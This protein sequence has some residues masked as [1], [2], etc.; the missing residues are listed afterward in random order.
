MRLGVVPYDERSGKGNLRYLQLTAV[1]T[2]P[3]QPAAEQDPDAAVQ[4]RVLLCIGLSLAC[5]C[6]CA[7]L[8]LRCSRAGR[9]LL[10]QQ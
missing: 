3:A 2:D 10:H 4:V 8:R 1:G 6:A 7:C 5:C 9:R